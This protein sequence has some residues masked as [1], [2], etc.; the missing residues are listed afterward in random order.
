MTRNTDPKFKM[1][2]VE[3]S[4]VVGQ[5]ILVTDEHGTVCCQLQVLNLPMQWDYATMAPKVADM[6]V[7]QFNSGEIKL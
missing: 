6:I 4:S 5:S 1:H 3:Y 2:K 7:L